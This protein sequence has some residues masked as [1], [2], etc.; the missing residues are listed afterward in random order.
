MVSNADGWMG[1]LPVLALPY[2]HPPAPQNKQYMHKDSR[3]IPAG[4]RE[5][6]GDRLMPVTDIRRKG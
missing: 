6:A 2:M 4:K 5:V 1:E 3:R